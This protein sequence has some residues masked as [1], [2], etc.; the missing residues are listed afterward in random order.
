L[1]WK[2]LYAFVINNKD[3]LKDDIAAAMSDET[4]QLGLITSNIS[5]KP[6]GFPQAMMFFYDQRAK[7]QTVMNKNV[8]HGYLSSAE[9]RSAPER[10]FEQHCETSGKI[11]WFYK[12]GDM[13]QEFFAI[14]YEDN[15]GKQKSF[16][17][18]YILGDID[19]NIWIVETKGGFTRSGQS[20]DIDAYTAKKFSDL[21]RYLKKYNKLGGI[22]RQ[23]KQSQKL[24]IC[25]DNYS[26][27]I[28]SDGWRL[29]SDVL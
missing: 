7:D 13:G 3:R 10:L 14:V 1:E 16:Y 17:P 6:I 22:V 26:D 2:D 5:E 18:D 29:L 19:G 27:D 12:N 15:F 9:V 25:T 23:D 11:K 20:E 24:C 21:Q 4:L 8:Y 28:H